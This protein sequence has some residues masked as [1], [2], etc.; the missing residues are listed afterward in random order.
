MQKALASAP[1]PL[2]YAMAAA[3][4]IKTGAQVAGIVSTNV[5]NFKNGGQFMVDGKA[6]V[7]ANNINMNV[8]KGERVTIE[9]PAQ[10]RANDGGSGSPQ[11]T[12][13]VKVVN[14]RDPREALDAMNTSEGEQ[15]VMNIM[16][17]NAPALRRLLG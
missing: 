5:G 8:S 15:V 6:G 14:V 2:N 11:V 10:Q 9:T 1:P 7:D 16:E 4:A 17:R 13:P 3:V 12:V